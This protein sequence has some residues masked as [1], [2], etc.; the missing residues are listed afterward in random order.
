MREVQVKVPG[1]LYV[2]GEYAVV[3]SNHSAILLTVNS[4]L[5]LSVK[6]TSKDYGSVYSDGF[7][8]EAVLWERVDEKVEF[9]HSQENLKY[10]LSA[11]RTVEDYV[12]ESGTSLKLYD[13][14]SKSELDSSSGEKF[15]LGSSGAITVAVT[16]GLLKFYDVNYTDL[17]IYK[18][19]VI[20]QMRLGVNSSFGDLAAIAYTGWIRYTNFDISHVLS[21]LF[22]SS[23]KEVVGMDW[24][25]LRIQRLEMPDNTRFLVGWTG[26]PAITDDMVGE[27]QDKK[28]LS[29]EQYHHFLNESRES[30]NVLVN[31]LSV[32]AVEF[33][34]MGI[35]RNRQAL[36]DMGHQTNVVI[37][38][39]QLTKLCEIAWDHGGAAKTS[40]AG[41]GDSGIAFVFDDESARRI[42]SEW[43]KAGIQHLPFAIYNKNKIK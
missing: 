16:E 14:E 3:E 10:I 22:H 2:A 40:G 1:K 43:K 21:A 15:G 26:S 25:Y 35:Q 38:T 42:I 39:P 37:E 12:R 29:P 31:A 5:T 28:D 20:A 23:V 6:E 18:L 4:F 27:V 8:D 30:V 41:G 33:I 24:P 13:I 36:L 7:T 19:S 32:N 17:L 34:R 11:M 9:K